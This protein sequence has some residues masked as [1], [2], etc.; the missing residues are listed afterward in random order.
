MAISSNY[1]GDKLVRQAIT[2]FD[3]A[4]N[5]YVNVYE[6]E[7]NEYYGYEKIEYITP[8]AV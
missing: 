2:I 3:P 4:I 5:K 8:T 1:R 7:G 6:K